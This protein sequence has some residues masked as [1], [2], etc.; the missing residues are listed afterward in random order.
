MPFLYL[1]LAAVAAGAA[2]VLWRCV[3]FDPASYAAWA[4]ILVALIGLVSLVHPLRALAIPGRAQAVAVLV[5]GVALAGAALAWPAPR[6]RRAA[7]QQR[8]DAFLPEYQFAEYHETRTRAPLARVIEAVRQVSVA[9]MPVAG[10]LLRLRALAGGERGDA[11]LD[12]APL[13][14]LMARSGKGFLVLDAADGRELVYGLTGQPWAG[15]PP[16][17][18]RT[19]AEFLAFAAPGH[20]RVAFDL[21]VVEEG[22]GTVRVST[23]TR[24]AGNDA[25]AAAT[26]ARYWRVVYPGSAIIRR[27]WLDAIVTRAERTAP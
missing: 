2:W 16:P 25:A 4:G 7:A 3:P 24:I 13:L 10:L 21:R 23:E 15:R 11:G 26:F 18:V 6:T 19:P 8:L 27:V 9:E 22:G 12:R 5:L 14:D 1:V 17:P 20:V